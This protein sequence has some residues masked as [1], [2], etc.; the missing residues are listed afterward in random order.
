MNEFTIERGYR[1][2]NTIF[3]DSPEVRLC[4]DGEPEMIA[5]LRIERSSPAGATGGLSAG[6]S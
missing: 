5:S 4:L 6:A 3:E 2:A 1:L